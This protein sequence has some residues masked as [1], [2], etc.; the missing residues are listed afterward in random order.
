MMQGQTM[1]VM[2]MVFSQ[3]SYPSDCNQLAA[4]INTQ[5]LNTSLNSSLNALNTSLHPSQ[6]YASFKPLPT[7][8]S[9]V[10]THRPCGSGSGSHMSDYFGMKLF[11]LLYQNNYKIM[12]QS[13]TTFLFL[14][15]L[16][17]SQE[18]TRITSKWFF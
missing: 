10:E 13:K 11:H 6:R 2:K 9:A 7:N 15:S 14:S 4:S 3:I 12:L 8:G 18:L 1:A 16:S 17:Q 5:N